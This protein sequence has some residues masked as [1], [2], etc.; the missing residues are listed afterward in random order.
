MHCTYCW[1]IV[2]YSRRRLG[3]HDNQE[4]RQSGLSDSKKG[5]HGFGIHKIKY[6]DNP[7]YM[8]TKNVD[9]GPVY[10]TDKKV[11]ES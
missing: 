6:V 7:V 11:E 5:R 8:R 1:Y 10:T 4:G 3:L 9:I 2:A